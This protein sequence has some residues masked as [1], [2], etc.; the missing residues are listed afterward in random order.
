MVRLEMQGA[1]L[2]SGVIR[3]EFYDFGERCEPAVSRQRN[4]LDFS[5]IH[6]REF[7]NVFSAAHAPHRRIM[8]CEA[9]S[10]F[11]EIYVEFDSVSSSQMVFKSLVTAFGKMKAG[12]SRFK[13]PVG[14][15]PHCRYSTIYLS[16]FE[17]GFL[18]T[19]VEPLSRQ[20]KSAISPGSISTMS[21]LTYSFP[22]MMNF[23]LTMAVSSLEILW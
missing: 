7:P 15:Y 14:Q 5:V 1:L 21:F 12:I 8:E 23:P 4:S 9:S 18:T 11:R 20:R 17:D 22:L 16:S 13:P 19:T 10:V 6:S 3:N 2:I